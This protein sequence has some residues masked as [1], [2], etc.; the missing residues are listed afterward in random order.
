MAETGLADRPAELLAQLLR[1]DTTNPPGAE[2]ECIAWISSVLE[3]SAV[4]AAND[5][6]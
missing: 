4:R 6:R 1:F 3:G 5:R 2:G